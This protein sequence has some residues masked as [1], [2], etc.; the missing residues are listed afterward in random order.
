MFVRNYQM[1]FK[2]NVLFWF[3]ISNVWE[4]KLFN[5]LPII[6]IISP[7]NLLIPMRNASEYFHSYII[8][9]EVSFPTFCPLFIWFCLTVVE[10][11]DIYSGHKSLITYQLCKCFLECC[12]PFYFINSVFWK[13][14][15]TKLNKVQRV[16]FYFIVNSFLSY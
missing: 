7:F 11:Q 9:R 1:V 8:F 15:V 14:K 16:S 5:F 12:V 3:L 6:G 4:I 10:L 2:V 13:T